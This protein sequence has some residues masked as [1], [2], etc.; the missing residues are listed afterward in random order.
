MLG[1]KQQQQEVAIITSAAF[2]TRLRTGNVIF[3]YKYYNNMLQRSEGM[4]D[5]LVP[6]LPPE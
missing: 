1:T 4:G 6:L 2:I 3:K 5:L